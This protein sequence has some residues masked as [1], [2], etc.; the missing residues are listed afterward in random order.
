MFRRIFKPEKVEDVKRSQ[1]VA[2]VCNCKP[3]HVFRFRFL[4]I[5]GQQ[6]LRIASPFLDREAVLLLRNVHAI[7]SED[8]L[9]LSPGL[10][11]YQ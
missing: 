1:S 5:E 7:R 3:C 4:E 9:I 11:E 6:S 2:G 10:F 8:S